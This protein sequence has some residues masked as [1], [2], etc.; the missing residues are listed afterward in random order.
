M[1]NM[2]VIMEIYKIFGKDINIVAAY[3]LFMGIL[4]KKESGKSYTTSQVRSMFIVALQNLKFM[5]YL[6]ATRQNT[7]LFKK[8]FYSKPA[9]GAAKPLDNAEAEK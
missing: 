3:D 2:T 5:G 4:S 9:L 7:F 8:N 1:E 6:S